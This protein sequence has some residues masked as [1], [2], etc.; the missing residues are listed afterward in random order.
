[1]SHLELDQLRV[2]EPLSAAIKAAEAEASPDSPTDNQA[3]A[4]IMSLLKDTKAE[5]TPAKPIL[6]KE[7]LKSILGNIKTP[8]K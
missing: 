3:R 7:T 2:E 6:K 8:P 4:Y 1:M 5:T